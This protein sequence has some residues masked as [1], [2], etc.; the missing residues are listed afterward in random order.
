[1]ELL[2][3]HALALLAG[4]ILDLI[5]GDPHGIPHPIC[6]IGK[7]ISYIEKKTYSDDRQAGLLLLIWVLFPTGLLSFLF[8]LACYN[9]DSFIGVIIEAILTCYCLATKSLSKES[10]K[11][12]KDLDKYGIEVARNS[13]SMIVGRD[14]KELSEEEICKATVETI[15]ENTSDGVI[16][17]MLYLAIGGPFLGLLYKAVNTLDS[18]VG[19]HN[20]KYENYGYYAAVI[21]DIVN[22]VPSRISAFLVILAAYI[23][24][25][26]DGNQ[27]MEIWKRDRLNHKSPNS[28][29]TESAYA[30]ALG[31][32]L[33]GGAF[34]FGKWVDKP[35][36]G[37]GIRGVKKEDVYRS[38]KLLYGTSLIGIT[39][40]MAVIYTVIKL[41]MIFL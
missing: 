29:Q 9:I 1:M 5:V 40:C 31:L 28:A 14:T 15:A 38:R 39:L 4:Y 24:K 19:Y 10:I 23:R 3:Y 33:G 13:L 30:G 26:F 22:F 32:R 6:L 34:Y 36:I 18:M 2:K 35:Y 20:D 21:D 12:V 16:A 17:P 7:W 25:G 37:D 27:A 11:V 41:N 8:L